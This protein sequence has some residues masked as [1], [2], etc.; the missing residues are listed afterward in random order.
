[1]RLHKG[2]TFSGV[3]YS[4]GLK[5]V[6]EFKKLFNTD[7]LIPYALRYVLMNDAVSVVIPGASRAT[8]VYSNVE[9]A[10]LDSLTEEQIK[11]VMEIYDK[12]IRESVHGNW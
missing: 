10:S 7:N 3:D 5:A 8:Q 4:L 2:E 9:A 1:M 6:D 11:G 12:Y